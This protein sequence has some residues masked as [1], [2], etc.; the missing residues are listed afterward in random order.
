M[1][2]V[3]SVSNT[4][5]TMSANPN[6]PIMFPCATQVS[7]IEVGADDFN[8]KASAPP[9]YGSKSLKTPISKWFPVPPK[10]V[11]AQESVKRPVLRK[12]SEGLAFTDEVSALHKT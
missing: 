2:I 11:S 5:F 4:H 7:M 1:T 12:V 6:R 9:G 3:G 8:L 10:S